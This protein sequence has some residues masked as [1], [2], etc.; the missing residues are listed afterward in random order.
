LTAKISAAFGLVKS[1]LTALAGERNT[2][3]HREFD[4]L[5]VQIIPTEK[6]LTLE[7]PGLE[8]LTLRKAQP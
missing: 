4:G 5:A 3:W 7:L 8:T 6:E 1:L 2:L